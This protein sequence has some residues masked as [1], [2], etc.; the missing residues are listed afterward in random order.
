MES[1]HPVK[2]VRE[3]L[4][5]RERDCIA[6]NEHSVLILGEHQFYRGYCVLWARE[7]VRELHQLA[8]SAYAGYLSELRRACEAVERAYAP[9]KLNLASLGNQVGHLHI[10]IFPRY[11]DEP[12]R[13]EQPWVNAAKFSAPSAEERGRAVAALR[14]ALDSLP[15][16][17]P[18]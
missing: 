7:P 12:S 4:Q 14:G 18:A 17:K 10:H 15:G 2:R 3:A 11:E 5:G 1:D 16:G 13:L 9:W 6:V 8:P